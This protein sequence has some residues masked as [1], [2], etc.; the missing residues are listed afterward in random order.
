M[1]NSS[2][3]LADEDSQERSVR[4]CCASGF[5][6]D[7]GRFNERESGFNLPLEFLR[8]GVI[9]LENDRRLRLVELPLDQSKLKDLLL[10]MELSSSCFSDDGDTVAQTS[11][12]GELLALDSS[13]DLGFG[14][15]E[16][17]AIGMKGIVAHRGS[18]GSS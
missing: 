4:F 14:L 18:G 9:S 12:L 8:T 10:D 1:H 2:L 17:F 5:W 16:E 7:L 15:L 3:S 6:I 13:T 11:G